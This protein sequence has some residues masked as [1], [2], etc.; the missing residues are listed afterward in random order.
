MTSKNL[1]RNRLLHFN[2]SWLAGTAFNTRNSTEVYKQIFT[3]QS[4]VIPNVTKRPVP[5]SVC[6]CPV[7][8]SVDCFSAY[9]GSIFPG[10][11]LTVQLSVQE[12]W[13]S[14]RYSSRAII[15]ENS[16]DQDDCS[17]VI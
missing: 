15:V 4:L 6:I 10:E 3:V 2:C 14:R 11:T 16:S 8:K 13:I 7:A 1:L 12:Q 17:I 9:L 5:L